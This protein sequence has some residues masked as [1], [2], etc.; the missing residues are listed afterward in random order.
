[1]CVAH[2]NLCSPIMAGSSQEVG[3]P[4]CALLQT[5]LLVLTVA[6]VHPDLDANKPNAG[7]TAVIERGF[8]WKPVTVTGDF[9][10][11]RQ[12]SQPQYAVPERIHL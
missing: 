12:P 10:F 11:R 4:L 2:D 5:I 1:M 7:T 6:V 9:R 3:H 8:Y